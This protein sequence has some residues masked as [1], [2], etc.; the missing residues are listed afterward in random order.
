MLIDFHNSKLDTGYGSN[1]TQTYNILIISTPWKLFVLPLNILVPP[2]WPYFFSQYLFCVT[3]TMNLEKNL[4]QLWQ[5][6]FDHEHHDRLCLMSSTNCTVILI[7]YSC[8]NRVR[9]MNDK[10]ETWQFLVR[11]RT[12]TC[13]PV[14]CVPIILNLIAQ[15]VIP[16]VYWF[17]K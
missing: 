9:S 15:I 1:S 11:L 7:L 2:P 3:N 17:G 13:V 10:V 12:W 4:D 14:T 6:Q 16:F 8:W 5:K